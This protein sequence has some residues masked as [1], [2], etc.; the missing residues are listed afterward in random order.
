VSQPS[1]TMTLRARTGVLALDRV[2]VAL[3]MVFLL[4][5]SFYLWTAGTSSPLALTGGS[6]D[7][8]NQLA[9]ALLHLHLS[10]GRAPAGLLKLADPYEPSQ[11][12]AFQ[13]TY[14]DLVLYHGRLFITWGPAPVVVLL[15]PLHLLGFEPTASLTVSLFAIVGLGFVLATLRIL[16]RQIGDPPLWMCVLAALTLTLASAVPWA[17]R[18]PAIYEEEIA[19]GYCF[20][21]A[22]IWL[23]FST[24]ADRR[25]SLR[26]LLLMSLCFGLA[27]GSRPTLAAT[28]LVLVPVYLSLRTLMPRRRLLMSL[29]I[30]LCVCG[31]L[32]LAYNQARFGTPLENGTRYQ[33]AGT[34]Q[35]TDHFTDLSYMPPGLWFYGVSP[36]R[37]GS[38]FPFLTITYP[39]VSLAPPPLSYPASFPA[40][41]LPGEPTGGLL[42]MAPIVI[43]LVG[44]PWL[45]RRRSRALGTLAPPL[46][47]LAGAGVACVL[48]LTYTFFTTT[49]R[50]EV[51]FSTLFLL[52]ALAAWLALSS[53]VHGWGRGLVRWGG[54]LLAVWSCL[55]GL[56]ISF[57]GYYNLL[58]TRHVGTWHILQDIGSPLS[59]ALVIFDGHP[60]LEEFSAPKLPLL[61][62][63]EHAN[64]V[65]VSPSAGST[66]LVVALIPVVKLK[67]EGIEGGTG[68]SEVRVS[69]PGN[70]SSIYQVHVTSG[71][72]LVRLPIRLGAGLN[73]VTLTPLA[74]DVGG[75][76]VSSGSSRQVLVN[77]FGLGGS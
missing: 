36:P 71:A 64:I 25:V 9:Q 50:Y 33:L 74:I 12:Q 8:Y 73:R 70:T 13:A 28:A 44:L 32:L 22:G 69:G 38:L 20:A 45:W 14:H 1:T 34:N 15:V 58:A 4:G 67:N 66:E 5:A 17:L 72:G 61:G 30:P 2:S 53:E 18:R 21:M 54:G 63:H 23:A 40:N 47:L 37:V 7:P 24:L 3:G 60:V 43:F 55:A 75:T 11:N 59:R 19:G 51:D 65:I 42:P 27:G 56:A 29:A 31:L 41:Y 16:L 10:I 77:R 62:I 49:E 35:L 52:G 57:T 39:P 68:A 76:K 46:L 48:F 26:R 6:S